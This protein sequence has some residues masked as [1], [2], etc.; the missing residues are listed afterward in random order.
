MEIKSSSINSDLWKNSW[1]VFVLPLF[2]FTLPTY[3]YEESLTKKRK[4]EQVLRNSLK[5]FIGLGK[6]VDTFLIEK[7]MGYNLE[8]KNCHTKYISEKKWDSRLVGERYVSSSDSNQNSPGHQLSLQM[9][10]FLQR[11][12]KIH[13][14]TV[15]TLSKMQRTRYHKKM[16]SRSFRYIP[17]IKNRLYRWNLWSSQEKLPKKKLLTNGIKKFPNVKIDTRWSKPLMRFLSRTI[18]R[19]RCSLVLLNLSS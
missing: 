1:Q 19:S 7:L 15:C 6:G 5:K 4:L 11:N 18:I 10:V 13:Q 16:F 8:N 3:F 2:E 14:L 17:P 9:Q 12:G